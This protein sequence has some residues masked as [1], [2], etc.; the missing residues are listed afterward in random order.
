M[1]SFCLSRFLHE[2]HNFGFKEIE[3]AICGM[4]CC[5][6]L[7]HNQEKNEFFCFVAK[8]FP[9]IVLSRRTSIPLPVND[10]VKNPD[11]LRHVLWK[12]GVPWTLWMSQ[13]SL[14]VVEEFIFYF[15]FSDNN[16]KESSRHTGLN[17][18]GK[19]I[20]FSDFQIVFIKR[21]GCG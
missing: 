16:S 20:F 14:Q 3:D 11:D 5:C 17:Q 15:F 4:C 1:K 7:D 2:Q 6:I 18:G 9:S 12:K 8:M 13:A 10:L 21:F 19:Y